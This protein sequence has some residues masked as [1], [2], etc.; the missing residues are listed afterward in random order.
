MAISQ[1]PQHFMV[2]SALNRSWTG[3]RITME[4]PVGHGLLAIL[5]VRVWADTLEILRG[6]SMEKYYQEEQDGDK[7]SHDGD[8]S[9]LEGL[10]EP[11]VALC[12][13]IPKWLTQQQGILPGSC[14]GK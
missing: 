11:V 9:P 4:S 10:Q 8:H 1:M 7:G 6:K 12:H 13:L 2:A 5:L 3:R 14:K